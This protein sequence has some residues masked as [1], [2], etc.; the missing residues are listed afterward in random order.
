MTTC[1]P[2]IAAAALLTFVVC[3]AVAEDTLPY[4]NGV[5]VNVT[6]IRTAPGQFN[7]YLRY[8]A[9]P[10]K[11]IM[12]EA[13]AQDLIVDYGHYAAQPKTPSD[14][15]LYMIVTYKNF[16]ALDGL[17]E[18]MAVIAARVFGSIEE[19]ERS[20]AEREALRKVIGSER[21]QKLELH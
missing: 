20:Q 1:L 11:Q 8:L 17:S 10:Y 13:K 18:K 12:E 3:G 15:N 19:A 16:A 5:V 2:R 7:N 21:L 4:T 9:G 14:P 6:S